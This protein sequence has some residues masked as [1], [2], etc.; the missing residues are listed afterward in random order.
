MA[1]PAP[2][3]TP[4]ALPPEPPSKTKGSKGLP[5]SIIEH[6]SGK[7]QAR[8]PG[9]KVDGKS[10][11]RPIP[12]LYKETEDAVAA[13]TTALQLF[14]SGGVEAVWPPKDSAPAERNKRG[15]VR[16]PAACSEHCPVLIVVCM[17]ANT[18]VKARSGAR[19]EAGYIY[20]EVEPRRAAL[21]EMQGHWLLARRWRQVGES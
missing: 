9:A 3:D 15:Q 18:G 11:Q 19:R 6:R 8:L 20:Q 16:Y 17:F 2:V 10:Y 21:E 12:G 13:Q 5:P 4:A 7:F 1:A 14:E